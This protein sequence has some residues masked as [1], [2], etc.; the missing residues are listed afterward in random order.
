MR[1]S[2][3]EKTVSGI[4]ECSQWLDKMVDEIYERIEKGKHPSFSFLLETL[5][6]KLM[7][8]ERERFLGL[9]ED[10]QA[11]GFYTR[12]LNL[13]LGKLNLRVPR[14]RHGKVFRPAILP[15][16]WKRVDKDYEQLLLAMLSNGYS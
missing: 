2:G 14:V 6:N 8:R 7:D 4:E 1:K 16:R 5:P 15:A 9:S 11:N 10:S 12:Q 3:K 13:S